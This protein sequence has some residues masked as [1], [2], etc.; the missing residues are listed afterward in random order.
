[1]TCEIRGSWSA[2]AQQIRWNGFKDQSCRTPEE[3]KRRF[4]SRRASIVDA[5]PDQTLALPASANLNGVVTDDGLPAGSILSTSWSKVTGPGTVTF[6]SF[7]QGATQAGSTTVSLGAPVS[8][9]L[10]LLAVALALAGG[11]LSGAVGGLRA[12]RLRPA[13]ALRSMD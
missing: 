7:G 4:E 1:M 12:A 10:I 6:G 2:S 13:E 5:G 11:L 9:G 3:A 8:I